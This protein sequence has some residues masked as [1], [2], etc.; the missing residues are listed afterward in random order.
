[1]DAVAK[2]DV[3]PASLPDL[4][5][6]KFLF[7][8]IEE[9]PFEHTGGI[10]YAYMD[11]TEQKSIE[12]VFS[13]FKPDVVLN[14]AAMTHVDQCESERDKCWKTNV[15]AVAGLAD[16][17]KLYKSRLI[18]ISTDFI[19]DGENGPYREED[20]A[21][22]LCVYSSSKLASEEV[23]KKS[24]IPWCILRTCILYGVGKKLV[25]KNIVLWIKD[26]LGNNQEINIVDDH[27]RSPT[28]AEDLASGCLLAVVKNARG[29]YNVSGKDLMSIYEMA[30]RLAAF[31]KLDPSLIH[32][33]SAATLNQPAK[34]PA[35]TGFILDKAINELNYRPHSFEEALEIITKQLSAQSD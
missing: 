2:P 34:R 21:N 1:M 12:E 7:T 3:F 32:P 11:I 24:A 33:I 23:L 6:W 25:R 20:K 17:C 22:P 4:Q 27:Y 16:A 8:S 14:T 26:Q 13:F 10:E 15:Q 19:F 28:L 35:K 29:V 31:Y 5:D 9:Q 18:H 30:L